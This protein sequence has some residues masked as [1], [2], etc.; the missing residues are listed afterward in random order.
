MKD[1]ILNTLTTKDIL[2][3]Y[4]IKMKKNMFS[5]PFHGKDKN[6]SA[7]AYDNSFYCFTCHKGGDIISFVEK[8]FNLSFKEAMQKINE[9]FDLRLDS[10]I[11]INHQKINEIKYQRKKKEEEKRKLYKYFDTNC[12]LKH[13]LERQIKNTQELINFNN[14]DNLIELEIELQNLLYKIDMKLDIIDKKMATL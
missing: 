7:K 8:Y 1:E 3:K 13:M 14:M 2:N 6:P 9:D 10:N 4:G 5:C 12:S 11:K